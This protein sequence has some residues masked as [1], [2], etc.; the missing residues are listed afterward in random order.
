M[1]NILLVGGS[2]YIG[3]VIIN[4]FFNMNIKIKDLDFNIYG[5]QK[6]IIRKKN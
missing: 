2:G 3:T 1:K 5:D 4:D 6:E